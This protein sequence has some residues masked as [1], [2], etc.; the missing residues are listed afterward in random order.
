MSAARRPPLR[1]SSE[2]ARDSSS[3]S[4]S[5]SPK[6]ASRSSRLSAVA[7]RSLRLVRSSLTLRAGRPRRACARAWLPQTTTTA[8]DSSVVLERVRASREPQTEQVRG[9]V[10]VAGASMGTTMP[11]SARR[12]NFA[13]AP[14]EAIYM[15]VPTTTPATLNAVHVPDEHGSVDSEQMETSPAAQLV[16]QC[17]SV[18]PSRDRSCT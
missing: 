13:P 15:Q 6:V 16:A 14:K 4:S 8:P 17:E 2:N 11:T 3:A 7:R 10:E 5:G 9:V 1:R 12:A 18:R